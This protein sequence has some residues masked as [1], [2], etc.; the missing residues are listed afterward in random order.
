[1]GCRQAVRQRILI[2][3][4]RWFDPS[5]P[6]QPKGLLLRLLCR[7]WQTEY[8]PLAQLA[9]HLTFNQGVRS[10]NLR[11]VTSKALLRK[12]KGLILF[13]VFLIKVPNGWQ[14]SYKMLKWN[15]LFI[16]EK[17]HDDGINGVRKVEVSFSWCGNILCQKDEGQF[18]IENGRNEYVYSGLSVNTIHTSA[19]VAVVWQL[20]QVFQQLFFCG[21]RV[22][23]LSAV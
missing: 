19:S 4:S 17:I 5:H 14:E 12:Q 1:M 7:L 11:W 8:D 10:S 2:P 13:Y 20:D 23:S 18:S 21:L 16:F 22:C 9:E 3:S 6:S 15:R